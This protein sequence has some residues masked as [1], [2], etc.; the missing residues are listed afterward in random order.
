MAGTSG[1][2]VKGTDGMAQV[3]LREVDIERRGVQGLMS[4]EGLD[5]QKIRTA[6]IKMGTEGMAKGMA[7]EPFGPAKT[8]FMGMDMPGEKEGI[9]GKVFAA[10]LWEK[11]TSGLAAGIPVTG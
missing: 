10:L 4:Q 8:F 11:K 5:R 6:F 3:M 7:G 2:Q 1:R 9:N